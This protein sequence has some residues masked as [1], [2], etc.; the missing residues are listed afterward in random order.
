[1][2]LMVTHLPV[3]RHIECLLEPLRVWL[4]H[5]L[6]LHVHAHQC[7]GSVLPAR[8]GRVAGKEGATV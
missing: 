5:V 2:S 3:S 8:F 4:K 6:F 7:G 1:M